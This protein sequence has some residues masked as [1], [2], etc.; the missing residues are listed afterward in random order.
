MTVRRH[1][2]QASVGSMPIVMI[3]EHRE[4]ALGVTR[5]EQEQPIE[6]F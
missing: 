3:N 2:L 5:I 1:Q 6:A 4:H